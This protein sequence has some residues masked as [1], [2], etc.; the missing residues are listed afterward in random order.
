MIFDLGIPRTRE[1]V[2]LTALLASP[3]TGAAWT[4][5]LMM[6]PSR[7]IP[8]RLLRGT[9]VMEIPFLDMEIP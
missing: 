8:C 2:S 9:T 6:S 4:H 1:R 7:K 5:T 3:S